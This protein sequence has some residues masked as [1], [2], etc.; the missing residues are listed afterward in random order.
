MV[1]GTPALG[2]GAAAWLG[3]LAAVTSG[4]WTAPRAVLRVGKSG[5]DIEVRGLSACTPA[6]HGPLELDP[7]R[8]LVVLVH[9]CNFSDNGFASLAEVFEAHDQQTLCFKYDDRDAIRKAAGDLIESLKALEAFAP[10][11]KITVIGHSQGGLVSRRAFADVQDASF[12]STF[13]YQLVTV[14]APFSG[15]RASEHCGLPWLHVASLGLTVLVCQIIAGNKWPE[16]FPGSHFMSEPGALARGVQVHVR[17]AT[18]E[19]EACGVRASNGKCVEPDEI[20]ALEEQ[21]NAELDGD[22]RVEKAQIRAGH[23][24]IIGYWGGPP[25]KLLAILQEKNILAQTP[26]ERR[27]QIA[28]VLR[29]LYGPPRE[30]AP[31]PPRLFDGITLAPVSD[32]TAP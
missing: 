25:T 17:I 10:G 3:V 14:S 22:P 7:K 31:A 32:V 5:P 30:Q 21:L 28:S 26:P 20:F 16:I 1:L 24:E 4:C 11:Q 19:R 18:D 8:P 23:S 12:A 27:E 9:G 13:D 15:I 6:T 29:K 2:C